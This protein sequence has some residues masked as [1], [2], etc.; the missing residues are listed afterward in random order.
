MTAADLGAGSRAKELAGLLLKKSADGKYAVED[1][2]AR[3]VVVL[4]ALGVARADST[5][6]LSP[7]IMEQVG[8]F[9]AKAGVEKN[10]PPAQLLT[11]LENHLLGVIPVGVRQQVEAFY[12]QEMARGGQGVTSEV[13]N[14]LG[15]EKKGGVL[16]SGARPKGTTAAGPMA[17]F[18]LK[19]G[20]KKK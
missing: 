9:C 8:A 13:A 11:R 10:T 20:G 12:R 6:E 3:A 19:D 2:A 17:R 7:W 18:A 16:D 14:M 1:Q 15:L 5:V 4:L